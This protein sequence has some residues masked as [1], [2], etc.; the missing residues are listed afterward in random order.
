MLMLEATRPSIGAG[1]IGIARAAFEFSCDYALQRQQFGK[2]IA[3]HQAIA[4]KLADMAT[5]I[6]A[7]R[8][9]VYRAAWMAENQIPMTRG[10]GSMSKL[11]A[12][13]MAMHVTTEAVQVMGGYGYLKD[14]PVERFMRDAKLYCIWEGT[15]EIQRYVISRQ[16]L[17]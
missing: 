6:D 8:L 2:P 16:L 13:E 7:A 4:F 14:Y 11:F 5:Q 15:S 3:R 10:E 17:S 9:L 1:A 12:S